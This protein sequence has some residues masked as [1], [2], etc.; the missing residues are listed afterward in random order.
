MRSH[1]H[2]MSLKQRVAISNKRAWPRKNVRKTKKKEHTQ[3]ARFILGARKYS[4]KIPFA[5]QMQ[6]WLFVLKRNE[7]Q[8]EDIRHK[9][10][11]IH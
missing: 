8:H 3:L 10:M 2:E 11:I 1:A 7:I 5:A 9:V 4:T 6:L